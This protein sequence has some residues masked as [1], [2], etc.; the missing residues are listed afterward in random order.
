MTHMYIYIWS[1]VDIW[2]YNY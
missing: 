2:Q 1:I